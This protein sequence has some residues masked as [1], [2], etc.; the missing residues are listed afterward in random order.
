[1]TSPMLVHAFVRKGTMP[2]T[3][4]ATSPI[5]DRRLHLVGAGDFDVLVT[6]LEEGEADRLFEDPEQTQTV[7]LAHHDLL[8]ALMDQFDFLPVRLGIVYS[9]HKALEEAVAQQK[10]V[11]HNAMALCTAAGEYTV[12]VLRAKPAPAST[13]PKPSSGRDYLKARQRR[14]HRRRDEQVS[15]EHLSSALGNSLVSISRAVAVDSVQ[16]TPDYVAAFTMLSD[17]SLSSETI[18][19]LEKLQKAVSEQGCELQVRGPW[20][21]YRFSQ[22]DAA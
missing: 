22:G 3:W 8:C 14:A 9:S 21:P 2:M 12:K 13:A 7:A 17:R 18:R 16:S 1:M 11:L 4:Q 19:E 10:A 15:S 20:P 6:F 5:G